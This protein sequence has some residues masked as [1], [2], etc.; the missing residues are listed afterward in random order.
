MSIEEPSEKK[1]DFTGVDPIVSGTLDT[2]LGQLHLNE[3]EET[4]PGVAPD[5]S[6]EPSNDG[7]THFSS[8]PPLHMF[9]HPQMFSMGFIPYSQMMPVPHHTGFFPPPESGLGMAGNTSNGPVMFNNS[10][11]ASVFAAPPGPSSNSLGVGSIGGETPATATNDPL[12][13]SNVTAQAVVDPLASSSA[14]E[15]TDFLKGHSPATAF[16]RQT[17]HALSPSDMV[18][19]LLNKSSMADVATD[20]GLPAGSIATGLVQPGHTGLG[21]TTRA[22]SIS[23]EKNKN[24]P[25][26]GTPDTN[27]KQEESKL[28]PGEE[29]TTNSTSYAAAY[30][31]G[32]PLMQPNPVLSGHPPPGSSPAYGV[33]SPF[34]GA[35]GFAS[36]FQFSGMGSPNTQLPPHTPYRVSP[37]GESATNH[38]VP[39]G[40]DESPGSGRALEDPSSV[41]QSPPQGLSVNQHQPSGTPPPW[42]Y[43][44]HPFG[45]VPHPHA[46]SPGHPHM[47]HPNEGHQNENQNHN[48]RRSNNGGHRGGRSGHYGGGRNKHN[49]NGNQYYQNNGNDNASRQRKM[50]DA[51]RYADATLDQFIGNIY[52]LCKDQHGCRFLQKQLDIL[53]SEAADSIFEETKNHTVELMTDSFG[54]YLIQKLLERVTVEQR[55]T[56]AK[57]AAPH[58][59]YI[60]S[61]PHGTRALQK[62]VECIGSKEEANIII[63]SLKGSVV[64]LSKD[65]NGNHI[66]QKCLQKLQPNDVQFIFDAASEHCTEIA[67]HRHGC[68]VLQRCLDH[69]D[70]VQRQRLCDKLLSNIDHLTLDPFGNY[71]VQ[72]IITKESESGNNYFTLK[73]VQ[74]LKSKVTELSLHKFGSNVIEKILRT[75]AVSDDLITELLS[76]RA[77]ADIQ[78]LLNDGYGNY[79]LQTMLDV[80]HQNNHYLHESLVEIVRPLLVGP[81]RNTP[82]GRRIM[83]ILR[84]E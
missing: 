54:N 60:A 77:E 24:N 35:Y 39:D 9:P 79:V 11:D 51:A 61:N 1:G 28:V 10:N 49:K 48:N 38:Q 40:N 45:M 20:S 84:M 76:S 27:K 32:G 53:G 78:A 74:A 34:H 17:F 80:T 37:S 73:I 72:Y 13:A 66:V 19:P 82:H 16:R 14:I 62:L 59:V 83:G 30:P 64:E 25:I 26:F 43:G 18:D 67:T 7:Y 23:L 68:C 8:I 21:S 44:N 5:A 50:E 31:Y 81:I 15:A 75:P 4:G 47:M 69:G 33:P 6:I 41:V 22:Q 57:I 52:S 58:F 2:A 65:L 42:M 29:K 56:L 12:W 3:L 55:I 46:F 36:P 71:V 70:E 63:G